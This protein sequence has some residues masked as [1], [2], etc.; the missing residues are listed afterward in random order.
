LK[1]EKS[2][3]AES[4]FLFLAIAFLFSLLTFSVF[5]D[6]RSDGQSFRHHRADSLFEAAVLLARWFL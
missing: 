6:I 4:L 3:F 5:N 2:D 1:P